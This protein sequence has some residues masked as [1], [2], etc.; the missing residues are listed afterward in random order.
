MYKTGSKFL[1]E[2][3][4]LRDYLRGNDNARM[5]YQELKIQLSKENK[6]NKH[7]YADGKTDFVNSALAKL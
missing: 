2:Q 7:K 3:L 1:M 6:H 4:K 5:E